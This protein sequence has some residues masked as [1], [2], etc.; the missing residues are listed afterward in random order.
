MQPKSLGVLGKHSDTELYP[1]PRKDGRPLE[2]EISTQLFISLALEE[3]RGG[4]DYTSASAGAGRRSHESCVLAQ[5]SVSVS[6]GVP[7]HTEQGSFQPACSWAQ[8]VSGLWPRL[9]GEGVWRVL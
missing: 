2:T 7:V 6:H 5:E 1:K 4:R 8:E 3:E 9:W